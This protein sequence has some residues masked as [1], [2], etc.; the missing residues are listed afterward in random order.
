MDTT[1]ASRL[2][3]GSHFGARAVARKA[4]RFGR[5]RTLPSLRLSVVLP[6]LVL[7][8]MLACAFLPNVLAPYGITDMD[9][10]AILSPPTLHHWFGTDHFGRDIF[11]LLV[12]GAERSLVMVTGTVLIAAGLGGTLGLVIGYVGGAADFVLMRLVDV[13]M[14]VPQILM[15]IIIATALRPSVG[16]TI[17]A[18]GLVLVPQFVRVMRGKVIAVRAR[19]FIEASRSIGTG[20][21]TILFRHV[22]PHTLAPMFVMVTLGMAIAILL[23]SV[24]SFIGIGVIDD[25][26]D[27]G[28]LLSQG[29]DYVTVAWWFPTFPGLAITALVVSINT[30]ANKLKA[31]LT[32]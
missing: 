29:R 15:A 25:R 4:V 28:F 11:S 22:L 17:M 10:D 9:N 8:T 26:P 24:L 19:P 3:P 31:H 2:M 32:P 16:H 12:F 30:L 27:W 7:A 18:V 14:S 1:H 20:H 23:G 21:A 5:W 6:S 13:W